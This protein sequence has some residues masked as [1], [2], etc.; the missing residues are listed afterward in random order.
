MTF[1]DGEVVNPEFALPLR[2]EIIP[3]WLAAFLAAVVPIVIILIMQI[4]VRS[5]WDVNNG[6]IG[7]LYSLITAAVF[8][9][10]LKCLIGGLR[11]HFLDVCK[12]DFS[13]ASNAPGVEG[14]GYNGAG[15]TGIYFTKEICTGDE[16]EIN[17]SL[18]SFPSGHSTAA[19]AGFIYLAIYLN[20]KLKAFSNYHPAMWKLVA[21]YTPVL[22]ATLIAGALTIDEFHNWY[23][24]VAGAIIGSVMA[25]SAYRMCYASIWDWRWNHVPLH[26]GQPCMYTY[27]GAELMDAVFTRRAGWGPGAGTSNWHHGGPA[28]SGHAGAGGFARKPV[29]SGTA[30][31]GDDMV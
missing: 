23:D 3:I 11:P 5:F 25:F 8:Q 22:G 7:L 19:F 6:I 31:R 24:V 18:E 4:R 15:Y 26:R 14:S 29:G 27:E 10:F 16:K 9:V 21:I 12:P 20:A 28:T 17:D 30:R 13:L 2:K 1:S